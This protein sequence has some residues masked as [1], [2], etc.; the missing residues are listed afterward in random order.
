MRAVRAFADGR[1][2]GTLFSDLQVLRT[3]VPGKPV[4]T[5]LVADVHRTL[6][7]W[8]LA[9]GLYRRVLIDEPDNVPVLINLGTYHFRK[10]E[11]ALANGYFQRATQGRQPSAAAW[12]NL[13]LGFSEAYTFDD[14][15]DALARARAIRRHCGRQLDGDIEPRPRPDLSTARWLASERSGTLCAPLGLRHGDGTLPTPLDRWAPLGASLIV[16]LFALGFDAWRRGRPSLGAAA[17]QH[18]GEREAKPLDPFPASGRLSAAGRGA[19][20]AAWGTCCCSSRSC[21]CLVSSSWRG[22]WR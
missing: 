1:L 14:S 4:I 18:G 6:G 11:F 9:R 19:G 20:W 10:G 5:E 22:I 8:E 2:Y 16:A 7:Q 21:S 12:Y 3:A 15:R 13:S 17:R